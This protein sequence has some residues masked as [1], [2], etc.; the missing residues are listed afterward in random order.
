MVKPMYKEKYPYMFTPLV[1]KRGKN[2]VVFNNRIMMSPVGIVATGGGA[3][4]GRINIFGVD[5]WTGIIRGGFSSVAL[6]MEIPPEG[7]HEGVFNMDPDQ[8]NYMNMHLLQRAV[9]AYNGKTFAELIHGGRCMVAKGLE[10]KAAADS[11]Y[12]GRPVKGMDRSDME[13][14]LDL[15]REFAS[16]ARRSGF[17]GIMVH[18]A[19]GWLFH[20]FLSPLTN[21]RTDEFGGSVENRCRFPL[22]ALKAIREVIG[23][24]LIIELRLN[25]SD[26]MPGGIEPKDAAQQVLLLQE[27]ADMIHIT[28]G[29]RIDVTSR[30]KMHPTNFFP[31]E[32]NTYASEIVKNTPGVKI[33][34]GVVGAISDPM[35]TEKLLADG[36]ADYVLMARA[37]IADNEWVNKVKEGREEDIRPCLRCLYCLDHGRRKAKVSGKELSM[38]AEVNFDRR[39][40]VNPLSM[41]GISK[42]LIPAPKCSKKVAVVGGGV[43]GMNAAL[44]AANRGHDVTIFEK[45]DRLGGQALLSDV[46]WFKKEMKAYH[47][48][49]ERQVKKHPNIKI[50]MQ[51][52]ATPQLI[53]DLNPDVAIIAVGAEQVVPPIPGIE[54]AKMAFDVFGHEDQLGKKVVIIG[55]GGIGCELSIHLSGLGHECT[56]IEMEE[57]LAG[58]AE[59]TERMSILEYMEKEKVTTYLNTRAMEITDAGVNVKK[60]NKEFLV[61]ADTV[62][63]CVGTRSLKELRDTFNDVAFD[64]INIGDCKR[65]SNMQHAIETGFDAGYII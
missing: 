41:Q 37:A 59:L 43:A 54:N 44:S 28:C 33:P 24:D 46:M 6:P 19:H 48:W 32:H 51:T 61:P 17:D 21:T 20:D 15:C 23:D 40:V 29:T 3:D 12:Q 35:R 8:V 57:F 13:E 36:K 47:N 2:E 55:G 5:Y 16:Q 26:E 4:N 10:L 22:M 25:G 31:T 64:V 53:S 27:Y 62:I 63:V 50:M 58:N 45:T 11:V 38:A 1:I 7:A 18:M 49:L 30:P 60:D 56:V 34:I 9:H 39:C 14:V 52:E 65:A 42:K